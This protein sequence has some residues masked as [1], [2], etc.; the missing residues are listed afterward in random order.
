M[1]GNSF[2]RLLNNIENFMA[3]SDPTLSGERFLPDRVDV[4]RLK[5]SHRTGSDPIADKTVYLQGGMQWCI[6]D[7]QPNYDR[8]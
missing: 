2:G 8:P 7:R 1:F 3:N 6:P 4:A 5:I